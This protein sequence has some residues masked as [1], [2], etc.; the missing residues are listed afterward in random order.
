[1]AEVQPNTIDRLEHMKFLIG[2]F[3]HYYDSVNNKG[4]FYIGINTFILG[5]ICVGFSNYC[6]NVQFGM[7]TYV[8]TI[9]LLIT[10]FTSIFYTLSA[11]TPFLKISFGSNTDD[12]LISFGGIAKFEEVDFH[13]RFK[14]QTD[15]KII[16]DYQNQ[17][18]TLSKGLNDKYKWLQQAGFFLTIE[19]ITLIPLLSLLIYNLK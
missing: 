19:F 11:M 10:C 5:G 7:C 13:S 16:E 15:N 18:Y 3:D 12:S 2:R 9:V 6:K 14:D 1:M 4:S 8:V 17:I